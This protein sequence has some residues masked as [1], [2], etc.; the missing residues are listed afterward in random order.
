MPALALASRRPFAPAALR[1]ARD[2]ALVGVALTLLT[3]PALAQDAPTKNEGLSGKLLHEMPLAPEFQETGTRI[4]RARFLRVEAGGVVARHSHAD[5]PSI[6]YVL[7][8]EAVEHL[9]DGTTTVYRAGDAIPADHSKTHW[10]T[11]GDQPVEIL[12]VDI[13]VPQAN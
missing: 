9:D 2:A 5:R 10:W 12:A 13:Y 8:G 6:E 7:S 11:I 3:L 1:A 4:L